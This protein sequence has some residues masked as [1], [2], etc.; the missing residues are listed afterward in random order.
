MPLRDDGEKVSARKG[1]DIENKAYHKTIY[2]I[3]LTTKVKL[4]MKN[5]IVGQ[6]GGPTAVINA[7]LMGIIEEC[8]KNRGEITNL[9]G[10][11]NGIEGVLKEEFVDLYAEDPE[12]VRELEGTPGA[13]LGGC[14]YMIQ[15]SDTADA[16]I[17]R[18][19]EVFGR[20]G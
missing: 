12:R 9:Y 16:D 3:I 14:R 17:K 8:L 1:S 4:I 11:V 7:S 18:V 20:Y 2:L 10:A 6:S 15:S 13:A 5:A 19:F